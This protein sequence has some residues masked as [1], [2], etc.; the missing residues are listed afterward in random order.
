MLFFGMNCVNVL[1]LYV[2]LLIN[3]LLLWLF[4]VYLICDV[5]S[6]VIE[7]L[8]LVRLSVVDRFVRFVLIMYMLVLIVLV[9]GVWWVVL[10]VV[11]V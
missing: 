10:L 5:L 11:V 9:S 4:V 3:W 6:M 8:C 2:K 7:W 1:M